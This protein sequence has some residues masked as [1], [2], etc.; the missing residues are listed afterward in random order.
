MNLV[1]YIGFVDIGLTRLT[2][3]L[4]PVIVAAQ[5]DGLLTGVTTGA[6]FGAVSFIKSYTNPNPTSF[7]FNNPI[8]SVLPRLLIG[9]TSYYSFKFFRALFKNA[10]NK[11]A[12]ASLLSTI[13]GVLT[14]TVLVLGL[15]SLFY[16]GSTAGEKTINTIVKGLIVTNSLPEL[17]VC[18]IAV[19]AI[20]LALTVSRKN[21]ANKTKE[22]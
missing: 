18:M 20:T 13:V 3:L 9:V 10:K 19:P 21:S 16:G 7:C 5:N 2:F 14:N 17:V 6:A 11:T 8:V 4:I 15:M 22:V 12:L 1:P